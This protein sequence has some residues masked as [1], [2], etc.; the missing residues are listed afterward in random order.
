MPP[1]APTTYGVELK[2]TFWKP[3]PRQRFQK[4]ARRPPRARLWGKDELRI[5]RMS[6]EGRGIA[7]RQGKVVF[8][9]GALQGETVLAQCTA[10]KRDYD[11]ALMVGLVAATDAARGASSRIARSTGIAA[12]AP[13]ST[14]RCRR[15]RRTNRRACWRCSSRS[16]RVSRWIRPYAVRPG[17]TATG[18]AC[19]C[20]V[21]PTAPSC[22]ACAGAARTR[23]W[24]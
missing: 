20:N 10:V 11:E 19:W 5:E 3:P 8:V 2:Y 24:R 23:R 17:L 9:S 13:C 6:Q 12:A 18:C 15:S 14:G 7:S 21:L 1:A 4:P 22:W 16:R